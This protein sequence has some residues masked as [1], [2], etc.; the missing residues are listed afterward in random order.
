MCHL[1]RR[2][3]DVESIKKKKRKKDEAEMLN[4][5]FIMFKFTFGVWTSC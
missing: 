1:S 5:P 2:G 3:L 4:H